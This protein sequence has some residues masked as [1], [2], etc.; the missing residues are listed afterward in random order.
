MRL[1]ALAPPP[2]LPTRT[3]RIPASTV[4]VAGLVLGIA[5]TLVDYGM[6]GWLAVGIL[7]SFLAAWE[8][9]TM[10]GWVLIV[11][12]AVGQISHHDALSVQLLVLIAGLHLLHVLSALATELPWRGWISVSVLTPSLV[13]FVAIQVPCQAVAIAVMLLLAPGAGGHRPVSIAALAAAGVVA[14]AALALLLLNPADSQD[15]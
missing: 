3:A 8:P 6:N 1:P 10:L 12:F 11:F 2:E 9:R 4:R 14:L 13:R 15:R 7:L 5:L